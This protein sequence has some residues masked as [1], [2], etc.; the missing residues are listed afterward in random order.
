MLTISS[1]SLTDKSEI[2][3]EKSKH[4]IVINTINAHSFNM[5]RK[6]D[7]FEFALKTSDILL[8][9]G[10]SI[11][12]AKRM[13]DREKFVRFTGFDLF[14]LEL[15]MLNEKGGKCFFL[16]S[17][18]KTLCKI[19]NRVETYFP[20]VKAETFS[21][22]FKS[23]FSQKENEIIVSKINSF[24]PDLLFVGMTAPKQ[25]KWV[26]ENRDKLNVKGP[27]CTVGAVFDFYS[28]N[29]R[30]APKLVCNIGF[31]WLWRLLSE[32]K[33]LWKRYLLGNIEF[34]KNILSEYLSK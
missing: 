28:G 19:K 17:D 7:I 33:R 10:I 14:N 26:A 1:L 12:M 16:G 11:V 13:I 23:N 5:A 22:P 31:E 29:V 15:T 9:D 2:I 8:P 20:M 25:E 6:D 18:E 24:I 34:I 30:R 4:K 27:I 3:K 32:P 21:P